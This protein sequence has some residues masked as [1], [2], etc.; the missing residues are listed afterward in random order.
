MGLCAS[1]QSRADPTGAILEQSKRLSSK[2][3]F[4]RLQTQPTWQAD[5]G[6]ETPASDPPADSQHAILLTQNERG[7]FWRLID[8]DGVSVASGVSDDQRH[9]MTSARHAM[10]RA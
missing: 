4:G 7:W 5:D 2:W 1:G 8:S 9:A 3:D 10:E 6:D